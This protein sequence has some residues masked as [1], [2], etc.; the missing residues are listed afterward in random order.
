MQAKVAELEASLTAALKEKSALERQRSTGKPPRPPTSG[1]S[2]PRA[3]P[4]SPFGR[5]SSNG[6][7]AAS[8]L[9]VASLEVQVRCP[10]SSATS[11]IQRICNEAHDCL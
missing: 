11:C 10:A 5:A 2:S 6:G 7:D 1:G 3:A 8:G 9:Q 4:S